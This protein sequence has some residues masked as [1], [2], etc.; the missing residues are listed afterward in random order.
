KKGETVGI[1]GENGAGKSTLL[2]ILA[3]ELEAS[4]GTFVIGSNVKIGY[5]SQHALEVLNST[6]TVFEEIHDRIP[7]ATVGFVRNLLGSF[8][9]SGDEV[10]KKV[11]SLSGGEKSRVVLATILARPVNFLVL[12]EPTN[13]LDILSR[14]VLL[15]AI[16]RFDGTVIIVSHDRHFLRGVAT[17]TY[18]LDRGE[19]RMYPGTYDEY[20]E[21]HARDIPA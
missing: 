17:K 2:K 16:Q 18:E 1:I 9:F 11:G 5:F 10:E 14:E 3:G 8:L 15:D 20:L 19:L 12:D 7:D 13:H 4:D 21:R 6:K